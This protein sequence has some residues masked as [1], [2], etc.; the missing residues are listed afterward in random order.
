MSW[1]TTEMNVSWQSREMEQVG[2]ADRVPGYHPL[3][4]EPLRDGASVLQDLVPPVQFEEI[5]E[6]GEY[7][8]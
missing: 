4:I 7:F 8:G 3:I 5:V 2:G 6:E 1:I